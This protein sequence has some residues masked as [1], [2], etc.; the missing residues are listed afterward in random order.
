MRVLSALSI[1]WL[2]LFG[3]PRSA[4]CQGVAET[5]NELRLLVREGDRVRVLD[6]QGHET[7]GRIL[8]IAPDVLTLRVSTE[9]R[10]WRASDVSQVWMRYRDS[11]GN[12]ALWGLG[13]GAVIGGASFTA[14]ADRRDQAQAAAIGALFY[15]GIGA[16]IGVGVDALIAREKVILERRGKPTSA[17]RLVPLMAPRVRG[18]VVLVS[19]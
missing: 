11:L 12:G 17:A 16:G 10:E 18:A 14:L 5:L 3:V 13:V 9:R 1:V 19:F 2:L 15:G 8:S 6:A 4:A 7:R